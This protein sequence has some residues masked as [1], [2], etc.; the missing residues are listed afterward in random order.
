[1][2]HGTTWKNKLS[3]NMLQDFEDKL[4]LSSK[5]QN[6]AEQAVYHRK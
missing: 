2:L 5:Q 6:A 1:M 3:E 4:Q